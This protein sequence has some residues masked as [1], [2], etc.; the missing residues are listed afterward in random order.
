MNLGH[1]YLKPCKISYRGVPAWLKL[2]LLSSEVPAVAGLAC[3]SGITMFSWRRTS[4]LW[5]ACAQC[6]IRMDVQHT[7]LF[8]RGKW[9]TLKCGFCGSSSSA[10]RWLCVCGL[11]W[12]GCHIHAKSGFACRTRPRRPA[13]TPSSASKRDPGP[14]N[15][16]PIPSLL[17]P[18][19]TTQPSQRTAS[20]ST[21]ANESVVH[22]PSSR[23]P[24]PSSSAPALRFATHKKR[25]LA[26]DNRMQAPSASLRTATMR[27]CKRKSPPSHA[28]D[29]EAVTRL[30][31]ARLNPVPQHNQIPSISREKNRRDATH[32]CGIHYYRDPG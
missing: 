7:T 4:M 1:L 9:A 14:S 17:T 27:A 26:S 25:C 8:F 2:G 6:S 10:R 3:A 21:S 23:R 30:R 29:L 22:G 31:D 16:R 11:P 19:P 24:N 32:P 12:H 15:C 28:S 20:P 13:P 18:L 5:L